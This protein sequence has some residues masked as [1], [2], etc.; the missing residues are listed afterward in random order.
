[1]SYR[2]LLESRSQSL[3]NVLVKAASRGRAG[4]LSFADFFVE[5]I[6]DR[7]GVRESLVMFFHK[8]TRFA[9]SC[10]RLRVG[11]L[12]LK[13]DGMIL[14]NTRQSHADNI[15]NREAEVCQNSRGFFLEAFVDPGSNKCSRR[16]G[17]PLVAQ[18]S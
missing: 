5:G 7:L 2:P 11:H 6:E 4:R 9:H 10:P 15:G 18:I 13:W 16:H 14:G 1:M 3:T 17:Y 12:K 8:A